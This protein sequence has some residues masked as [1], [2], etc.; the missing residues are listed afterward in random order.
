MSPQ[1]TPPWRSK[2]AE[3]Q[4]PLWAFI[5]E[6]ASIPVAFVFL[7]LLVR[8]LRLTHPATWE[9]LGRPPLF[10]GAWTG[11]LIAGLEAVAASIRLLIFPF[12]PQSFQLTDPGTMILMWLVRAA[13]GLQV[14]LSIWSSWVNH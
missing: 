6:M 1:L 12:R 2:R 11:S 10:V 9:Q 4:F 13:F 7:G 8:R 3:P 5:T 14:I